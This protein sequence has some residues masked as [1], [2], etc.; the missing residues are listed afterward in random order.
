[1]II[2]NLEQPFATYWLERESRKGG[3]TA[4]SGAEGSEN[5]ESDFSLASYK[6]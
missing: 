2:Q 3:T 4:D 6:Y 1:M 5:K